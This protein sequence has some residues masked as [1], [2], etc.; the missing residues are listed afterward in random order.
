MVKRRKKEVNVLFDVNFIRH[1]QCDPETVAWL[2]VADGLCAV[3]DQPITDEQP[4]FDSVRSIIWE[5]V[6]DHEALIEPDIDR[7]Y[8][9]IVPVPKRLIVRHHPYCKPEVGAEVRTSSAWINYCDVCGFYS[10]YEDEQFDSTTVVAALVDYD[11][12]DCGEWIRHCD[13]GNYHY[14]RY[15]VTSIL[16][17]ED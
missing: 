4:V 8:T 10:A 9:E 3:C 2:N 16:K 17:E 14:R 15:V 5:T 7:P 11:E 13:G 12:C 6:F 1:G